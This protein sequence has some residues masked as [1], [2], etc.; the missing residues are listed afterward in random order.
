MNKVAIVVG[1][2]P[3]RKAINLEKLVDKAP[4]YGCNALYRDFSAWNYLIAIDD[5]MID[6]IK[7]Y[8]MNKGV[9]IFPPEEQRWEPKE[10]SPTTRRRNNAGMVAMEE[11]IKRKNNALYCLGFDFILEGEQSVD[12]VYKNTENYGPETHAVEEDNYHRI[13]YLEWFAGKHS[14]VKF[15]FV[16]PDDAKTKTLES[17][18]LIGMPVSKFME[19]LTQ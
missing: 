18:N 1:N 10:Y 12:N 11:A 2:G 16:I 15:I 17:P 3:S 9:T 6:E 8:H 13:K 19:K 14:D 7:R 5:G 4:I